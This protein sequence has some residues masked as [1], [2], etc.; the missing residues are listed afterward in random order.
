MF[1]YFCKAEAGY[2]HKR[3]L[4]WHSIPPSVTVIPGNKLL[5][6]LERP[7]L[8]HCHKNVPEIHRFL[9]PKNLSLSCLICVG[10]VEIATSR[11]R[12]IWTSVMLI[13]GLIISGM[14][15][16]SCVS[17]LMVTVD[18]SVCPWQ[19]NVELYLPKK[20]WVWKESVHKRR[21]SHQWEVSTRRSKN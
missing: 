9:H 19:S 11:S 4:W 7:W 8:P 17:Q 2:W 21:S 14:L 6:G 20:F 15:D 3:I 18:I 12:G 5:R 1:E 16:G 10:R 13:S